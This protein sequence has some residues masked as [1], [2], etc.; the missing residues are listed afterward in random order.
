MSNTY[1]NFR[2]PRAAAPFGIEIEGATKCCLPLGSHFAKMYKGYDAS[3]RSTADYTYKYELVSDPLSYRGLRK[4]LLGLQDALA[5]YEWNAVYNTGIHVHASARACPG[6]QARKLAEAFSRLTDQQCETLF[7]RTP[8]WFAMNVG[9]VGYHKY[10]QQHRKRG[11][12]TYEFRMFKSGDALW[13]AE[14]LRRTKIMCDMRKGDI[15]HHRLRE[16]FGIEDVDD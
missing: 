11:R 14:C 13:A 5:P 9:Y 15:T 4:V 12:I 16:A 6:S 3:I 10:I 8:G 1:R 2:S 7:G